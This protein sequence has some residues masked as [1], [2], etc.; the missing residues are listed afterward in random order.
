MDSITYTSIFDLERKGE[1]EQAYQLLMK[2]TED[3]D[4]LATIEL[5]T[6]YLEADWKSI[7]V[8]ELVSDPIKAEL[9]LNEGRNLLV[10][11]SQ[12][13]D[14]EAMR[15]L[16]YTYL[17]LLGVFE[18]SITL[19]EK[20]LVKSF[21]AGCFFAANDLSVLYKGTNIEKARFYYEEAERHE[22]RV[23]MDSDLES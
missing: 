7:G 4:P 5:G 19:G 23:I 2:L 15:M 1:L 10:G 20:W 18:R 13:G 8:K 16:G 3:K 21:E 17:G 9:L 14:A 6:R 12:E 11:M 22:C